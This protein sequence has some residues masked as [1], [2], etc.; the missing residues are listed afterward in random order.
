LRAL[1]DR[2]LELDPTLGEAHTALGIVRLFWDWDWAGAERSLRRAVALNP[3]DAHAYHHLAN[4]F[5]V[6]GRLEDAVAARTRSLELD[7]LNPRTVSVLAGDYLR[8]GDYERAL[9][10]NR[11]AMKLDPVHPLL[12]G[13]G[14]WLPG[15]PGSVYEAQGRHQEAVDEYVRLATLRGATPAEVDALHDAF[16]RGGMPA[17]WRRWLEMDKRQMPDLQ[18]PLRTAKLWLLSGDTAQALDWLDRAF[19]ERNPGLVMLR[20]LPSSLDGMSSHPR[21]ARIIAAMK[22]PRG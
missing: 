12:L 14:P 16:A 6:M 8:L 20:G 11:R 2:A 3:S 22:L 1:V 15:G 19:E 7:P 13:S 5:R 4:Y 17:F 10:L 9:E 21:V 18:D